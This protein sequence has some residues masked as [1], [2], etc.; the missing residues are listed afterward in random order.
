MIQVQKNI[1]IYNRV[2]ELAH[3]YKSKLKDD[4]DVDRFVS[5]LMNNGVCVDR[6]EYDGHDLDL[7]IDTASISFTRRLTPSHIILMMNVLED[8]NDDRDLELGG[9]A[10]YNLET[11]N[12]N[13]PFL[14]CV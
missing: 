2:V 3:K 1:A 6:V 4:L 9:W 10:E 5:Y 8:M 7:D 11:G 12:L 13:F 14:S